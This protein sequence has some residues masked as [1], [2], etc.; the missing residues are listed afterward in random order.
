[1]AYKKNFDKKIKNL[2]R[3]AVPNKNVETLEKMGREFENAF[4]EFKENYEKGFLFFES[5]L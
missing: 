5:N 3:K 4:S 1:M 2:S